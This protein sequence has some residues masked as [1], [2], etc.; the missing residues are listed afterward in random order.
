[1]SAS[2]PENR[3]LSETK[4]VSELNMLSLAVKWTFRHAARPIFC[5]LTMLHVRP[6]QLPSCASTTCVKAVSCDI[7]GAQRRVQRSELRPRNST[8]CL[9]L[10]SLDIECVM[11]HCRTGL[12]PVLLM[13]LKV[14]RAVSEHRLQK[15]FPGIMS[16][17]SMICRFYY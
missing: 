12:T 17:M 11:P 6:R 2:W 9:R 1:M 14:V 5:M 8:S 3:Q 16:I 7:S 15:V 10:T 4:L 13:R